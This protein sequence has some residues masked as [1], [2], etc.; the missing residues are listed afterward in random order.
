MDGE[1]QEQG[2]KARAALDPLRPLV[3]EWS[4]HGHCYER[5]VRGVFAVTALLDGSWL[6]AAETL[7]DDRNVTVHADRS[8]YRYNMETDGL[9]VMQLFEHA[10][11]SISPVELTDDGFRW[12]TGPGAPQL[13]YC[14]SPDSVTYSVTLPGEN[15][16]AIRMIYTRS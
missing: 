16:P 1:W 3:G 9:E 4:G 7:I 11:R 15:E 8:F 2:V 14:M 13:R 6:E 12:I 10:H 5:A